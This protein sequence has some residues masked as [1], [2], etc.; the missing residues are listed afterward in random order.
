[1]YMIRNKPR[2]PKEEIVKNYHP[3]MVVIQSSDLI[4]ACDFDKEVDADG[5]SKDS[6]ISF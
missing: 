4:L 5:W 1:M 3:R 6:I 2:V